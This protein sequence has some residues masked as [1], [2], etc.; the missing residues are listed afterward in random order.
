MLIGERKA[1]AYNSC[2]KTTIQAI[3][4]P[5]RLIFYFLTKLVF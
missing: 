2:N 1:I 4:L 3:G 5:K